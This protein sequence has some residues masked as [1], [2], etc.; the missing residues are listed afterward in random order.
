[1]YQRLTLSA[2]QTRAGRCHLAPA[3]ATPATVPS[4]GSVATGARPAKGAAPKVRVSTPPRAS[5]CRTA[6]AP[7]TA[8]RALCRAAELEV[9]EKEEWDPP[10]PALTSLTRKTGSSSTTGRLPKRSFRALLPT[11]STR[12]PACAPPTSTKVRQSQCAPPSFCL[13]Q[14][15]F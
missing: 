15:F 1:M 7:T 9:E 3:T 14:L 2:T 11:S 5:A 8:P 4:T 12:L 10:P 6:T 13:H